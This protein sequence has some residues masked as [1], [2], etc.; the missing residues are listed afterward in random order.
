M[1]GI[2]P[3]L[4]DAWRLAYPYFSKQSEERWS[5][6]GLLLLYVGFK[7][8]AV[9]IDVIYSFWNSAWFDTIQEHNW[10]SFIRLLTIGDTLPSGTFMPGFTAF[11]LL[12]I[13]MAVIRIYIAQLLQIRWRRWLTTDF[14]DK[15]M[16]DRAYYR[17]SLMQ[18]GA[19]AAGD[20]AGRAS[21][22]DRTIPEKIAY[23]DNPDQRIA[24][25]LRDFIG[26]A[27]GGGAG[28]LSLSVDLLSNVVSLFSFIAILWGLSDV[29]VFGMMIPGYLVWIALVYSVI[30][31]WL[32]H[33]VGRR[34][35]PL[36]FRKQRVEADFRFSLMRVREYAEGIALYGGEADEKGGLLD[37][38][39]SLVRN[40]RAMMKRMIYLNLLTNGYGQIAT[41]L[42]YVIASPPYFAKKVQ[43]GHLT[44]TANAFSQVQGSLS[45]FVD[46]YSTL[47]SWRATVERLTTFSHA[48]ENARS[49][50]FEGVHPEAGTSDGYALHDATVA[51]PDGTPLLERTNIEL[52]PGTPILLTGRSGAGKSTLF[53]AFAGIWPFGAGG[54]RRPRGSSLFLPQ[55]PYI[56]LGTLRHAVAYPAD[57]AA[58][59]DED[60]RVALADVGLD[61]LVDRLDVEDNWTLRL[62]GG[63]QQ[64][65]AL[66]RALL[67]KPDWLFLDEATANLDPESEAALYV[68]IRRKLP[69]TT[70]VSIAHRPADTAFHPRRFVLQRGKQGPGRLVETRPEA[71][72]D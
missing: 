12:A 59:S 44:Q 37:R 36:N 17:I 32:T 39:T 13:G 42:P 24:E 40:W 67:A 29:P 22:D 71:A 2:I 60:V 64:R 15:W 20:G 69:G 27:L 5:A 1:R 6:R 55:R 53:R 66:A 72:A 52:T 49:A 21:T 28:A 3:F 61:G 70:L 25:D 35:I 50:Q 4:K 54:V 8:G 41:V 57:D 62:S 46:A 7:L 14:L 18:A 43:L 45:W 11:A 30:G 38:F 58:F 23:T 33:L 63:E 10:D 51:L 56:P 9:G 16:S 65:L 48:I 47:A 34:L 26:D 19:V 68:V 31:T